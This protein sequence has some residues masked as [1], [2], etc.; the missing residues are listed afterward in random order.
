MALVCFLFSDEDL[1]NKQ[2][3]W[4][5]TLFDV[6][7]IIGEK[8]DFGDLAPFVLS[9][10]PVQVVLQ[11]VFCRTVL[12]ARA[13]SCV[14]SLILAVPSLFLLRFIGDAHIAVY[15]VLL[16][17]CGIFINGPYAIITTAVSSDLGTHKSIKNNQ[18]AKAT[19]TAIIDGTGSIGAALGPLLVGWLS[20]TRLV[21][22]S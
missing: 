18:N 20:G 7:G 12:N 5:S 2:S 14:V 4:L 19:V 17:L 22:L 9:V 15:I 3:D 8:P 16:I 6:G 1:S 10:C 11:L 13:L 21:S